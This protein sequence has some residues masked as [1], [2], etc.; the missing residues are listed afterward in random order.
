[1]ENRR[2]LPEGIDLGNVLFRRPK[3]EQKPDNTPNL[4]DPEI[5]LPENIR[6]LY[7]DEPYGLHP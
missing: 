4:Q 7:T 5:K 2:T 6:N 1:M 3:P